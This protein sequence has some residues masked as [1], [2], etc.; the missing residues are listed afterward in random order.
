[1][2]SENQGQTQQEFRTPQKKQPDDPRAKAGLD[3]KTSQGVKRRSANNPQN[4]EE[5]ACLQDTGGK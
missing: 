5:Y 3:G 2:L 4:M 1:M